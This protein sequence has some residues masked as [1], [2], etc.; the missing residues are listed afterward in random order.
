[1]ADETM[2]NSRPQAQAGKDDKDDEGDKRAGACSDSEPG[3][4]SQGESLLYDGTL[5]VRER[6][7]ENGKRITLART[8]ELLRGLLFH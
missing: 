2:G 4:H 1:M 5:V 6:I 7:A 3:I 8:L